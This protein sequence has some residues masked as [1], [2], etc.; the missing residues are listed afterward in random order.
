MHMKPRN[1]KVVLVHGFCRTSRN[2]SYLNTYLRRA[3][4]TTFAPTLPTLCGSLEEC[5]MEFTRAF[6]L[7]RKDYDRIHFVAH[8]MGGLI[9]RLFLSL[10]EVD[11]LG[12]CV[13]IATPNNGTDLAVQAK[14]LC[15]RSL[16][17]FKPLQSFLPGKLTIHPPLNR[18]L[19]EIGV[20]A[21]DKNNLLFSK[22]IQGDNDGR[23]P[24]SSVPYEGIQESALV[25]FNHLKIHHNEQV[26]G[27]VVQFIKS[28]KF[29]ADH[30][31]V[32]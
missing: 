1:E 13:L 15:S 6:Q 10:H 30:K 31:P 7:L 11:K 26:A 2:M 23:V 24:V 29:F 21:G 22:F 19:P 20:I 9:V 16:Q 4:Y 32:S 17:I 14:K 12:R 18:P 25:P 8:S 28:G 27:M 3:G 5:T